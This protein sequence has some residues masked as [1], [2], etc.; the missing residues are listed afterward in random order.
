[1]FPNSIHVP[2]GQLSSHAVEMEL[3][4]GVSIPSTLVGEQSKHAINTV[5][6]TEFANARNTV[7]RTCRYAGDTVIPPFNGWLFCVVVLLISNVSRIIPHID[8]N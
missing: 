5:R 3:P 1:M 2:L 6:R 4:G 7:S 8:D